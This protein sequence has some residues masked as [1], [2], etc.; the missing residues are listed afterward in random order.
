MHREII[1]GEESDLYQK[2]YLLY[3]LGIVVIV[4]ML[5][6]FKMHFLVYTFSEDLYKYISNSP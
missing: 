4:G 6:C 3:F 5:Q 1:V 2:V